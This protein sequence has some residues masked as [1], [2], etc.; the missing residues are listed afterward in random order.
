MSALVLAA[1]HAGMKVDYRG[2]LR[3]AHALLRK[4]SPISAFM[5]E[6][7]ERNLTE[8]G[9]RY[10]SGDLASVDEFLQ[11]YCINKDGRERV[12]P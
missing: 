1:K 2:M 11:L 8:L 7:L 3:G 10:Y 9:E 6:E 12:S 4:S 5:L